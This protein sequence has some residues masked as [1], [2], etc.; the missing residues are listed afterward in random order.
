MELLLVVLV[1]LLW[2]VFRDN[3]AASLGYFA[4]N[5]RITTILHVELKIIMI[6][7]KIPIRMN[8]IFY[9][10]NLILNSKIWLPKMKSC[11]LVN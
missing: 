9:G 10:L 8:V 3:F 7:I 1:L 5:L 4:I 2:E 11:F 6:A